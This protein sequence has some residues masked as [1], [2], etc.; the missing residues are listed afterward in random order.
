MRKLWFLLA[1]LT[2][3]ASWGAPT[4]Y[5]TVADTTWIDSSQTL[6]V[7]GTMV[8]SP[9]ASASDST[10]RQFVA[11]VAQDSALSDSA[12]TQL[13]AT[14]AQD[15]VSVLSDS[16]LTQTIATVAQDSVEVLSDSALTQKIATV[17]QDSVVVDSGQMLYATIVDSAGGGDYTTVDGAID[18]GAKSIFIRKGTYSTFTLDVSGIVIEGL[19][20][21]TVINGGIA[22]DAINLTGNSNVLRFLTVKT[23]AGGGSG[24]N[25]IQDTGANNILEAVTVSESD[26]QGLYLAG[27][28]TRVRNCTVIN[29]DASNYYISGPNQTFI[30]CYSNTSGGAD[31]NITPIGDNAIVVGCRTLDGAAQSVVIDTDAENC[32]VSANRFDGVVTDNSGTS[33]TNGDNDVEAY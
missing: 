24:Y 12:L 10:M 28:G 15:S 29:A 20:P 16:A 23:T 30:G 17:A 14:V 26:N 25:G 31:Y 21:L 6:L 5:H 2:A 9:G 22:D 1:F 33:T 19:G 7:H 4:K 18:A 3:A 27:T 11:T 8:F 13:I 32:Q